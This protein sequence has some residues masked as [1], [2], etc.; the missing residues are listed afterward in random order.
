MPL[1]SHDFLEQLEVG[2]LTAKGARIQVFAHDGLVDLLQLRQCEDLGQ[3]P[4]RDRRIG[5][6]AAQAL[7]RTCDELRICSDPRAWVTTPFDVA[8][9]QA[10]EL[11]RGQA[12]HV[13]TGTGFG[14]TIERC[15]HA[16][17]ALTTLDLFRLD[18]TRRLER[19][20]S[21]WLPARLAALGVSTLP[22]CIEQALGDPTLIARFVDDCER[23]LARVTLWPDRR[24]RER[25]HV[26]FEGAQGLLLDQD[27]GAF[28]HVTRSHTGLH[29][30]VQIALEAQIQTIDVTYVTRCYATRHGAGPLPR[31]GRSA[32]CCLGR[33]LAP[34]P[35][36][37]S[38]GWRRG[39]GFD[40]ADV[41]SIPLYRGAG[42]RDAPLFERSLEG[43]VLPENQPARP[44]VGHDATRYCGQ[45]CLT[46]LAIELTP[47]GSESHALR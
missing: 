34:G 39:P 33:L 22:A 18:L 10:V 7:E 8:I 28:P 14:E 38:G 44:E 42:L 37:M 43:L 15:Q 27:Y 3:E 36:Q 24:V 2:D 31:A 6:L 41:S 4:R 47:C 25:G 9:N 23:Y 17:F 20:R 40:D 21:H 1:L 45:L 13:S 35:R 29:N 16:E 32:V 5:A 30:M 26:I 19:I 11:A 12:R 46:E